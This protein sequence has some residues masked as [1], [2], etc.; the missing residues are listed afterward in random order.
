MGSTTF[1]V[2]QYIIFKTVKTVNDCKILWGS[3][4]F[5]MMIN[6]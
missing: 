3:I 1:N 5:V 6:T 2:A 4:I